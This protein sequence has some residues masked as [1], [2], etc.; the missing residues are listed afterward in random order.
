MNLVTP[1]TP[2]V[3]KCSCIFPLEAKK[4][5]LPALLAGGGINIL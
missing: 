4:P 1:A 5:K 3:H 2:R